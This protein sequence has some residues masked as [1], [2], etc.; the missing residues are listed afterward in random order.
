ML[1]DVHTVEGQDYIAS[2]AGIGTQWETKKTEDYTSETPVALHVFDLAKLYHQEGKRSILE[3][4]LNRENI[5]V[6]L[7]L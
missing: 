1:T 5:V 3:W 2:M 6:V 7:L 4:D